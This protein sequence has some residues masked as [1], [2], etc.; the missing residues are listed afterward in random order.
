MKMWRRVFLCG[1]I[2]VAVV[3]LLTAPSAAQLSTRMMMGASVQEP[4]EVTY[5]GDYRTGTNAASYTS[6]SFSITAGEKVIVFAMTNN[7][8]GS[9]QLEISTLTIT[10]NAGAPVAATRINAF[11]STNANNFRGRIEIWE[12]VVPTGTAA[13]F[14]AACSGTMVRFSAGMWTTE[15]RA[16]ASDQD[17]STANP[18]SLN[19]SVAQ[20]GFAVGMAMADNSG[21]VV[22]TNLTER[23]DATVESVVIS[24]GADAN[25]ADAATVNVVATPNGSSTE[26]LLV[27]GS[28]RP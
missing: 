15:A 12:A 23:F 24:S 26:V 4:V 14:T 21:S 11:N 18:M 2:C 9:G 17:S 6:G 5:R 7:D 8:T 20:G 1:A 3:G 16:T 10:P 19:L 25:F 28:W 22:W 27:S 13:T